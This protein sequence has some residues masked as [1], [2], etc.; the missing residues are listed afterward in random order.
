[1]EG[2]NWELNNEGKVDYTLGTSPDSDLN[3]W[4]PIAIGN[5]TNCIPP[6][7]AKGDFVEILKELNE[8]GTMSD[9]LGFYPDTSKIQNEIAATN[10]VNSEYLSTTT[11][12]HMG[13][14]DDSEFDAL[15]A[16]YI[17]KIYANECKPS[18]MNYKANWTFGVARM[19]NKTSN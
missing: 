19:E 12:L 13:M 2:Q 4:Y 9:N 7:D 11:G 1:L 3:M 17:E 18:S 16:E 14:L 15:Y 6:I 5:I 8:K 10:A